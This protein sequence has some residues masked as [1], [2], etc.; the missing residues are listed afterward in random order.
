MSEFAHPIGP[1]DPATPNLGP[2]TG[3]W[4][5][6]NPRTGVTA[7]V[8]DGTLRAPLP[9]PTFAIREL[10]TALA[11]GPDVVA[12]WEAA[13]R[14]ATARA[15]ADAP[16]LDR[17]RGEAWWRYVGAR[18]TLRLAWPSADVHLPD[19]LLLARRDTR[20]VLRVLVWPQPASTLVLPEADLV[21]LRADPVLLRRD[22]RPQTLVPLADVL[23]FLGE[24][25]A[26]F[27]MP[28][29]HHLYR[30]GDAHPLVWAQVRRLPGTPATEL[31]AAPLDQIVDA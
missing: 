22:P 26:R 13:N 12:A 3:G 5:Y 31:T 18:A 8:L 25:V 4:R 10:A 29:P 21:A 15:S 16:R 19:L 17:A 14:E 24:R 27:E 2:E 9:R 28:M 7:R 6:D 23:S 11:L 20:E 30:G 1:I